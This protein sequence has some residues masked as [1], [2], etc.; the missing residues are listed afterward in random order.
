MYSTI[1]EHLVRLKSMSTIKDINS[2]SYWNLR[3]EENWKS[4][5]GPKQSRFFAKLAIK[6]L[7]QW[8]IKQIKQQRLT[9]ADFGCAQGDGTDCWTNYI[10]AGQITGVDFS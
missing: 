5:E 2:D 8:L 9:L 3:F 6:N 4:F 7:P 10:N 1:N